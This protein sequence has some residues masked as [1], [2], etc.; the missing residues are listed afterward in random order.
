MTLFVEEGNEIKQRPFVI[1]ASLDR[2]EGK[3]KKEQAR[4]MESKR[5]A[6]PASLGCTTDIP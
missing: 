1:C 5:K 2:G 6:C 4:Q 3:K